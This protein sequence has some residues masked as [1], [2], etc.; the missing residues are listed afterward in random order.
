MD[1]STFLAC[2]CSNEQLV[3]SMADL[4]DWLT[5]DTWVTCHDGDIIP[6]DF[7]SLVINIGAA[8]RGRLLESKDEYKGRRVKLYV[9]PSAVE[10]WK[11]TESYHSYRQADLHERIAIGLRTTDSDLT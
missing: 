6:A 2:N 1:Y 3:R 9:P 10:T 8:L 11:R 5:A 7:G 4:E